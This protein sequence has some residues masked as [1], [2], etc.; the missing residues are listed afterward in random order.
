MLLGNVKLFKSASASQLS[1]HMSYITAMQDCFAHSCYSIEG[2][3]S[4]EGKV[5]INSVWSCTG[6]NRGRNMELHSESI[7]KLVHF[8]QMKNRIKW[9]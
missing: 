9:I 5:T 3:V 1:M 2:K 7:N 8:T 4:T 6:I